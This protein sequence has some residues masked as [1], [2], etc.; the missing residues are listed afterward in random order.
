MYLQLA[1]QYRARH[2]KIP[3]WLRIK[4]IDTGLWDLLERVKR[5]EVGTISRRVYTGRYV[6]LQLILYDAGDKIIAT[7]NLF[8]HGFQVIEANGTTNKFLFRKK[9]KN[10]KKS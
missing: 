8:N 9:R 2:K 6:T 7:M 5:V 4:L 1:L 3:S 10:K